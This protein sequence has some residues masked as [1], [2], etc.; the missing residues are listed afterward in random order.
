VIFIAISSRSSKIHI[1]RISV[2]LF[3]RKEAVFC[4][5]ESLV[6]ALPKVLAGIEVV[7]ALTFSF[8]TV[9][10]DILLI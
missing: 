7:N 10:I 2:P 3:F 8:F 4:F 6:I 9:D 5:S 1:I